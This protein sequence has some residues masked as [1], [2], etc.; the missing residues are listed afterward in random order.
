MLRLKKN[1]INYIISLEIRFVISP[2]IKIVRKNQQ[3]RFL[4][5]FHLQQHS[6]DVWKHINLCYCPPGS[7]LFNSSSFL[8]AVCKLR[9]IL[10]ILL[11]LAFLP[12]QVLHQLDTLS[13]PNIFL[14]LHKLSLCAGNWS[15]AQPDREFHFPF[16]LSPLLRTDM[17]VLQITSSYTKVLQFTC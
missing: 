8:T 7:S 3:I 17:F 10:V 6:L 5:S 2:I 12:N 16:T 4:F 1:N 9:G 14:L 15:S 13:L 11:S